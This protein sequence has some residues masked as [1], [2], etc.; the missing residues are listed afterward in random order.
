MG[1]PVTPS[2][3]LKGGTSM[4]TPL[5]AGAAA[6]AGNSSLDECERF[7]RAHGEPEMVSGRQEYLENLIN[8]FI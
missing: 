6:L 1:L 4:S 5:T 2:F 3:N 8:N 7:I